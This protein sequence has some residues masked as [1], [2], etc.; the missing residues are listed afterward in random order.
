LSLDRP[1]PFLKYCWPSSLL[2]VEFEPLNKSDDGE[3][4]DDPDT[5]FDTE[6]VASLALDM[7]LVLS[8]E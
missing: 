8:A 2:F 7:L 1:S 3:D 6:F 5:E 4:E